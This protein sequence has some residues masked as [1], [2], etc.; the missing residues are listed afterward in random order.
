MNGSSAA[1][2]AAHH[3]LERTPSVLNLCYTLAME[4]A[5]DAD[6]FGWALARLGEAAP[7]LGISPQGCHETVD[8]TGL[9][10]ERQQDCV[11]ALVHQERTTAFDMAGDSRLRAVAIRLTPNRHVLI[12]TLHHAAADAW[13]LSRYART[14]SRAYAAVMRGTGL[15]TSAPASAPPRGAAGPA[16]RL[17]DEAAILRASLAGLT[18]RECDPLPRA[19]PGSLLRRTICFDVSQVAAL[20]AAATAVRMT[21]FSFLAS[22]L[23]D[24]VCEAYCLPSILLGTTTLNRRSIAEMDSHE[25]R[26]EGA[27]FRAPRRTAPSCREVA[28]AAAAAADCALTYCEQL[29]CVQEAVG[30]SDPLEPAIF[31]FAD[32]YPMADLR[33]PDVDIAALDVDW[34]DGDGAVPVHSPRCG[35]VAVFWRVAAGGASLNVFADAGLDGVAVGLADGMVRR[36]T[37]ACGIRPCASSTSIAWGRGLFRTLVPAVDALSPVALPRPGEDEK[38]GMP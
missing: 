17:P 26:Y 28:L 31:L 30:C 38:E 5:F 20:T 11:E 22:L 23:A 1:R 27:V 12:L 34:R 24:E 21:Q 2:L 10:E 4:G 3:L 18:L 7:L 29:A 14:L 8:A 16:R 37:A 35:R 6:A 36:L 32:R 19:R 15:E 33:L 13:L 25:V 9:D